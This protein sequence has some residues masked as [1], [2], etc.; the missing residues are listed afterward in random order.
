MALTKLLNTGSSNPTRFQLP[1][2][3][4]FNYSIKIQNDCLNILTE[5]CESA[6]IQVWKADLVAKSDAS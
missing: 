4:K 1:F 6:N 5:F 2:N 3:R